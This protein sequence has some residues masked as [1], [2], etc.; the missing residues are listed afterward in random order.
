MDTPDLAHHRQLIAI[1]IARELA[2]DRLPRVAAIVA[3]IEFV[4]RHVETGVQVRADDKRRVPIPSWWIF[5]ASGLRLNAE[6][7]AGAL[8]ETNDHAVLQRRVYRVWILR[9]DLR[10]KT[11]AALSDKPIAVDDA[12]S[13]AGARGTTKTVVVLRAAVNVVE[14]FRIVG[15][16]V[17]ELRHR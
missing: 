15:G 7:F 13:A 5:V 1:Q 16:D 6:A 9:I 17:V 4:R 8:V 12:R 3:A 14:R 11:G 2:A 10:A